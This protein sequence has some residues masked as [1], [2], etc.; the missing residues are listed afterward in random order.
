VRFFVS[1][2]DAMRELGRRV[3]ERLFPGAVVLLDGPLGAGKT[4]FAQGVAAGLGIHAV[5]ASPTYALVHEYDD[6]RL[7]LRHADVYRMAH[8]DELIPAGLEERVG[9]D[10]AWL[11]EWA[12][13]FPDAWPTA[14]LAVAIRPAGEGREV[15]FAAG[16]TRHAALVPGA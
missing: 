2:A 13:R 10:G 8:D 4:T 3:G 1:D 5:V 12:G 9:R 7:P 15:V 6:G 11:V 16:D 14:R